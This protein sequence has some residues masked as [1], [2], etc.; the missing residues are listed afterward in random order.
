MEFISAIVLILAGILA[1][2]GFLI[3]KKPE[4]KD[5]I[6]K[7]VPFQGIIGIVAFLWGVWGTIH[8]VLNIGL[9]SI[10][11]IFWVNYLAVNVIGLALGFLLGFGLISKYALSKN[12]AAKAKAEQML[13]K[14]VNIQIPLGLIAICL[15]IWALIYRLFLI[16]GL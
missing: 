14:L 1:A 10:A 6:D 16:P 2:S 12:E 8:A 15:G 11:P 5:L 4:A 3:K 13:K 7:L 9:L